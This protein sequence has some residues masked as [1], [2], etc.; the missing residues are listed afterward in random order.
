LV[1]RNGADG[2]RR[3]VALYCQVSTS[4]QDKDRQERDLRVYAERA[5][6]EVVAKF[7]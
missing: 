3:R 6:Y 4:D 5:S 1:R 2:G 7:W